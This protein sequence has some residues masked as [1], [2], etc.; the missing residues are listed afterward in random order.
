MSKLLRMALNAKS[1]AGKSLSS[2]L[3]DVVK[4]RFGSTRLGAS[5]YYLY[6]L[7]DDSRYSFS[8]KLE[9]V[10]W[11]LSREIDR[12]LNDDRWRVFANDKVV[13]ATMMAANSLRS[14]EIKAIY[15]E[16]F[17]HFYSAQ[18][19]SNALEATEYL[20]NEKVYPLF[21]KPINGTY[22]R[23]GFSALSYDRGSDLILHG[24]GK[25]SSI[26]TVV[27]QFSQNW[28]TG[29]VFQELLRPH[30]DI[31][32]IIGQRLSSVRIIVLLTKAGP[33]VFRA[34]WKIPTGNN[35]SDNFMHGELGNTIAEI[36]P[37]TGHIDS[38][39][40]GRYFELKPQ[41]HHPDTGNVLDGLSI[42]LWEEMK[43]F[44]HN[45]AT[46]FP[47]LKMQHWDI[48]MCPD[49]PVALEVNVEGALDLS[50]LS[51]RKGIIDKQLRELLSD[52]G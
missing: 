31:E 16:N 3:L 23:G 45:G 39:V 17:R 7:Y 52:Y 20:S 14:P 15:S 28:V 47:G 12:K 36:D 21:I 29:Y 6:E 9:F 37:L 22:G 46:L 44:C 49:G 26:K 10:G 25:K 11:R 24:D 38:V 51:G 32:R 30:P 40:S 13:F 19:L 48:A 35:M 27:E 50:Q 8:K 41:H 2:Q 18:L 43:N 1:E 34:V 33:V 4:L 42:P 5:E